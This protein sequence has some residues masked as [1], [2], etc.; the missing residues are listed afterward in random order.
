MNVRNWMEA[1]AMT[2]LTPMEALSVSAQ[3]ALKY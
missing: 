3:K 1:V 2:A